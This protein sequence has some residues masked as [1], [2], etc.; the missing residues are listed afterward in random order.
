MIT[1][2]HQ[3]IKIRLSIKVEIRG[4]LETKKIL[5]LRVLISFW[6]K[7]AARNKLMRI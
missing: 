7:L 1:K 5:V 3:M 2:T 6:I 4:F